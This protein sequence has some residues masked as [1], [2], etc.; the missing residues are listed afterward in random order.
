MDI[1]D[2]T[3]GSGV[4]VADLALPAGVTTDLPPDELVVVAQ[5]SRAAIELEAEE[6]AAAEAEEGAEAGAEAGT[7][8]GEGRRPRA[9]EEG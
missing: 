6:A 8:G 2:L 4:R 7:A 1:A 9:S 3:V 5:V